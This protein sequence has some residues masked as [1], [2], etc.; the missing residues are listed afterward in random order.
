ME[1]K[2]PQCVGVIMDGNR[3][4]AKEQGLPSLEGH[5][6]GL[7]NFDTIAHAAHELGIKHFAVYMLSTENWNR[8]EAEVSYLMELFQTAI[9]DAFARLKDEGAR[10]HFIGDMTRF[11]NDI[12]KNLEKLEDETKENDDFHVWICASYGGRLE[13]IEA[14]KKLIE[15]EDEVTEDTLK[16]HMWS[17]GMPDPD[18]IIRTGGEKRLSN[19]LLWQGAYAELFFTDTYWPAFTKQ[20]L[21]DILEQYAQRDRRYGK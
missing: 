12:Q 15:N 10:L 5:K 11:P 9:N 1:Q 8:A 16:S 3:R 21:Q 18:I 19:F 13:I 17:V 14:V 7:G 20:E 4:W 2:T 6:K